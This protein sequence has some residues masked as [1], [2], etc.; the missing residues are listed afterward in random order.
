MA[1]PLVEMHGVGLRLG[2]RHVLAGVD[3]TV[4][5]GALVG[6]VGA[7]GGGKTTTLRLIAGLLRPD[8]GHG[9]VLGVALGRRPSAER[10]GYMGQRLAL[11]P[12]LSVVENLSFRATVHGCPRDT[13]DRAIAD[14]GLASV[15]QARLATLSGGWA[16]RAQFAASVL[17]GPALLLLDE[18]TA[19]LDVVTR[20]ALWSW[21]ADLARRG[22]GIVI[23]TH[24][25]AEAER[26]EAV[27]LYHE[28]R[29]SQQRSP[30]ALREAYGAPTLEAVAMARAAT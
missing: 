3:L 2:G 6:L 20:A 22:T 15:A 28:G 10:L 11:Y 4:A 14:Y 24:D 21:L 19:G 13:V 9:R 12:E 5:P 7:N 1:E 26:L 18:P 16:R 30:A 27:L 8:A 25:L 17:H 29:P 23:S